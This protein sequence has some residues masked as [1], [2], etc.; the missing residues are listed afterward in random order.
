MQHLAARQ[1]LSLLGG[2]SGVLVKTDKTIDPVL[3]LIELDV[4]MPADNGLVVEKKTIASLLKAEV[5]K[6]VKGNRIVISSDESYGVNEL[7]A[8]DGYVVK[9]FVRG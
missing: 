6:V 8:D 5:G 9:V 4:Q 1:Q 2:V 7:L 3:V